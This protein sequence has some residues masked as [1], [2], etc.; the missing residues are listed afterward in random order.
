MRV[1]GFRE[2]RTDDRNSVRSQTRKYINNGESGEFPI[3]VDPS[4]PGGS[5][6][7]MTIRSNGSAVDQRG[8]NVVKVSKQKNI[9]EA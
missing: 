4:N 5:I 3:P 7:V 9:K 8:H 1:T 6:V 2:L